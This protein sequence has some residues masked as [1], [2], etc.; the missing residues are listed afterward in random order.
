[1]SGR[2]G[3]ELAVGELPFLAFP[4]PFAVAAVVLLGVGAESFESSMDA[5]ARSVGLG[6]EEDPL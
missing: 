3:G 5:V 2:S 1:L 6:A 4:R